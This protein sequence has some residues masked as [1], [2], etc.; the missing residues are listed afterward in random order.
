MARLLVA[1]MIVLPGLLI[2]S[3][4]LVVRRIR[5]RAIVNY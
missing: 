2:V 1:A 3:L 5:R 4:V